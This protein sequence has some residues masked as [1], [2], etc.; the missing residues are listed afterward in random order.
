MEFGEVVV[1][2]EGDMDEVD[3]FLELEVWVD[4]K[5]WLELMRLMV[6]ELELLVICFCLMYINF[7][8]ICVRLFILFL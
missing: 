1:L 4:M 6:C 8:I 7:E 3:K 2:I 5:Y